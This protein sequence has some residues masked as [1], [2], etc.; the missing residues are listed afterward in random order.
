MKK[1]LFAILIASLCTQAFA[2][3]GETEKQCTERYGKPAHQLIAEKPATSS[4]Q[5]EKDG[6]TIHV[7]FINGKAASISYRSH[8]DA[9]SDQAVAA[10]LKSN[11]D[12]KIWP[13]DGYR[14]VR[15][16]GKAVAQIVG[17]NQGL[18]ISTKDWID[19]LAALKAAEEKKRLEGF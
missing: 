14:R 19:A 5:Y 17:F 6:F 12:D 16:D 7:Q 13:A 2:R 4:W 8:E 10:F 15:S 9:L 11:S 1:F 18:E 3:L